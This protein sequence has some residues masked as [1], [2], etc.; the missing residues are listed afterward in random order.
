MKHI[1]IILAGG[2]GS[3]VGGQTPKQLLPLEDGRSILEHSVDAF[4]AAE[5]IDEIA[6]VMHPEWMDEARQLCERNGWEKVQKIC[7]RHSNMDPAWLEYPFYSREELFRRL[8][9]SG[10]DRDTAFLIAD[11]V[12]K[13]HAFVGNPAWQEKWQDFLRDAKMDEETADTCIHARYLWTEGAVLTRACAGEA[14]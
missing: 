2:T 12:R 9:R 7:G 3:R 1:A 5:C 11:F 8:L 6:I 10:N 14:I 13:G 4:E